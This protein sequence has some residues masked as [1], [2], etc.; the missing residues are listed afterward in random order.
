MA[1]TPQPKPIE[2]LSPQA[3][4]TNPKAARYSIARFGQAR[5]G[6]SDGYQDQARPTENFTEQ[7]RP[8]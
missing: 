8:A 3:R 7:P 1:F 6:N 2:N 4:P 5:F